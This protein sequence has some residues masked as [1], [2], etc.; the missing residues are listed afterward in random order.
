VERALTTWKVKESLGSSAFPLASDVLDLIDRKVRR[1]AEQIGIT[2]ASPP[3]V[4]AIP[5][6]MAGQDA[7]VIAPTGSGKTEAALLPILSNLVTKQ[8]E[9]K[10]RL[11]YVTPMRALNRDMLRR[12]SSWCENLGL[13]VGIRHGDTPPSERRRQALSPPDILITTP[14]TLQAMLPSPRLGR[15][16]TG[17]RH[18]VVDEVHELVESRRGVQLAVGLERL[19]RISSNGFQLIGLSATVSE[20]SVASAVVFGK[21]PVAIFDVRSERAIEYAVELPRTNSSHRIKSRELFISPEG[22]AR[23]ERL[24]A[25]ISTHHSVLIFVNSRTLAEMISSRLRMLDVAVGVHHGSLP[26]EERVR[27]EDGFKKGETR[28]IICTS[29]LELGI[30]IGSVDLVIQY[31]SPRQVVSLVQRVGRSGHSLGGRA[32]GVL[33]GVTPE[34]VLESE[35][36][37]S[38]AAEGKLERLSIHANSLDVLAHQAVGFSLDVG[39]YDV[40]DFLK[41][42]QGSYPY[43]TITLP[44]LDSLL[45]YL[46]RERKL[47]YDGKKV[48]RSGIG[49]RYYFENL[50]MIP[51]ERRY[52]VI[53]MTS[54][55]AIG[56]LGEEFVSMDAQI[57]M[58]FILKGKVWKLQ[59]ITRDAKVF[60]TPVEDPVAAIPGWDGELIPVSGMV[61]EKVGRLRRDVLS[62]EFQ[63]FSSF[64]PHAMAQVRREVKAQAKSTKVVP[65]DVAVVFESFADFLIVHVCGGDAVNRT[66]GFILEEVFTKQGI[67]K[68][69]WSDSYR[70][71]FALTKKLRDDEINDVMKRLLSSSKEELDDLLRANFARSFPFG[72][73]L[74]FVAQRFGMLQRGGLVAETQYAN[75]GVKFDGTPVMEETMREVRMGKIDLEG[76][77]VVLAGIRDDKISYHVVTAKDFPSPFALHILNRYGELPEIASPTGENDVS[78]LKVAVETQVVELVCFSCGSVEPPQEIRNMAERPKCKNCSS[79][80]LSPSFWNAYGIQKVLKRKLT[81]QENE[82]Q[83]R[84]TLMR[85]RQAADLVLS[86]G[87]RAIVALGVYGIGPQTASRVLAK[88][89]SKEDEFYRDLLAA[90]LKFVTTRPYWDKR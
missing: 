70:I 39:E 52:L 81:G 11:L 71:L 78:R 4:I 59:S 48:T 33:I 31:M 84:D 51:D 25:L 67:Q 29:T 80:L 1:A 65:S 34:D 28:C 87:R 64:S 35:A 55:Q 21:R 6:I 89:H 88:M 46:A 86:Y 57:G 60:V 18:V 49:R 10:V 79:E 12:L 83:D 3:Q 82:E 41:L 77:H 7:L 58:N 23:L 26:K 16:L 36:I 54:D 66:V 19:R 76:L 85:A 30:D 37:V 68:F 62:N 2:Q 72:A 32:K 17:L 22:V 74:K 73:T 5:A 90:K 75:L 47:Y 8:S 61:A 63:P 14:E 53:D 27:V 45:R 38:L 15:N 44:E 13:R 24:I 40:E 9:G 50:S 42:V 20:P 56:V 43:S 69:W